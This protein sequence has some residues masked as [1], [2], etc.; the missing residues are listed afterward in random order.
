M[1]LNFALSF[2]SFFAASIAQASSVSIFCE[3]TTSSEPPSHHYEIY[4]ISSLNDELIGSTAVVSEGSNENEFVISDILQQTLLKLTTPSLY[5]ISKVTVEGLY[6]GEYIQGVCINITD[7]M[8][9]KLNSLK[10]HELI[11]LNELLAIEKSISQQSQIQ[12][13]LLERQNAAIRNELLAIE[14]TISQQSQIQVEL[15]E[16]QNAAIREPE[17]ATR[18]AVEAAI[19]EAEEA[20]IREMLDAA[21]AEAEEAAKPVE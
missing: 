17:E 5:E 11:E 7:Q 10:V 12:V 4:S 1:K 18:E 16:C 8:R 2:A 20:A 9:E 21:I 13:E 19:R 6:E 3:M 15:L 14:K